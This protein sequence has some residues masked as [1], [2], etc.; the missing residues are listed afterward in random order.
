MAGSSSTI[1]ICSP[2]MSAPGPAPQAHARCRAP[3]VL[4]GH[5]LR[6]HRRGGARH[7]HLDDEPAA[8]WLVVLDPDRAAV[9]R[10]DLVDYRQPEAHPG[11]LRREVGKEELLLVLGADARAGVRD[12]DARVPGLGQAHA[13]DPDLSHGADRL[14]RVVDE[15]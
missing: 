10:D 5:R 15:V 7:W 6:L 1:K 8:A 3:N 14:D 13:L 4:A 12:D 11:D 9:L 2:A